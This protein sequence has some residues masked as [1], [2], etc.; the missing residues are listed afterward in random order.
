MQQ[1]R[2]QLV[3]HSGFYRLIY[4]ILEDFIKCGDSSLEI[5]EMLKD[6]VF[7]LRQAEFKT[8]ASLRP[9]FTIGNCAAG[10]QAENRDKNRNV[11][12]VPPD[13]NRP[14]LTSFQRF[15]LFLS[16]KE[17]TFVNNMYF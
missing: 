9:N 17:N 8:L 11:L 10:H 2:S 12:V 13:D 5:E 3:P 4:D 7:E 14:Y 15:V 6:E 16:P 1:Q